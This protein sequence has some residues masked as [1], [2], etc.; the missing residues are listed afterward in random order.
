MRTALRLAALTAPIWA[1]YIPFQFL[2]IFGFFINPLLR[3]SDYRIYWMLGTLATGVTITTLLL[4][5]T[6]VLRKDKVVFPP[7]KAAAHKIENVREVGWF[8][9]T[10]EREAYLRFQFDS[11]EHIDIHTSRLSV[12]KLTR[13]KEALNQWAPRCEFKV[14]A[15]DLENM[16]DFRERFLRP[17]QLSL[18]EAKRSKKTDVIDIPYEPH[19]ELKNFLDSLGANE[20]WFWYCWVTVLLMPCVYKIPDILWGFWADLRGVDH[21]IGV[22]DALSMFDWFGNVCLVQLSSLITTAG[23]GYVTV[24]ANPFV[25]CIFLGIVFLGIAAFLCFAWQPNRIR[26]K[27]SGLEIAFESNKIVFFK[28]LHRWSGMV[29]FHLDQYGDDVNPEKW[30]MQI[31]MI[32]GGTVNLNI[33]SIKGIEAR[34]SLLRSIRQMC[35]NATLDPALI[36]ALSPIQ[37]Q[38]YTELWLQ[39]LSTP[40]KRSRLAPL[41]AGQK[42][43]D[44][45]Y[46]IESQLAVGGQGVAYLAA[47]LRAADLKPGFKLSSDGRLDDG[48]AKIVLKE[49]VLP[50]YTSRVVRKQALEKFENEAHILRDLHHPQIVKLA[51]YFLEDHRA[52][53]VLEHID[54][55]SLS[56]LVETQGCLSQE[57]IYKLA[58]QM[59]TVLEYLHSLVPAVVHRDFTPD[60]LILDKNDK[61]VLIDFNVAQQNQWTTTGTVVGKHA[62]LPPEQFRGQPCP[63]SDLYAMG[64]TLFFL[65]TG[66]E[67]EPISSS[68][69]REFVSAV[70]IEFDKFVAKLTAVDLEDRYQNIGEVSKELKRLLSLSAACHAQT[71]ADSLSLLNATE[72]LAA[73][74]VSTAAESTA[75]ES[76]ATQLTAME[77]TTMELTATES[78]A[79]ELTAMEAMELAAMELAAMELAAMELTAMELTATELTAT[80]STAT[81]LTASELTASE[82]TAAE[83]L[84]AAGLL[85]AAGLSSAAGL[86]S[87]NE[88]LPGTA[89]R[90]HG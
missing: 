25:T 24:A 16:I 26:L 46:Q 50:V 66:L 10:V 28:T 79:I 58:S 8:W 19:K 77:L 12:K 69:P 57:Q 13:L 38:S 23:V 36:Q 78:T 80:E 71:N 45:Q 90:T 87:A 22:P 68:H 56:R 20:K 35:P 2:G 81:E 82:L 43:K 83:L 14:E 67:P 59:C 89:V 85:S 34:Q 88:L 17:G 74:E 32:D 5:N 55:A 41:G 65:C 60:N 11:A 3:E 33:E 51:D 15:A 9:D 70:D 29:A 86:L 48:L 6:L 73:T 54:G 30:R 37:K 64:A 75:T 72:L 21:F 31:N 53:L 1:I 84:T 49:F 27:A 52:Y 42:L 44:G 63:Q 7:L 47:D 62:Y 76:T 4:L 39:S 18:I 61:L 40:P